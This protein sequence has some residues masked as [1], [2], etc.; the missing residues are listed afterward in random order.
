MA[1]SLTALVGFVTAALIA[2]LL[3]PALSAFLE[4]RGL[5]ADNYRRKAIP[6]CLGLGLL[7][8]ALPGYIGVA[9]VVPDH[10]STAV[11]LACAL[12]LA[13]LAGLL[14]DVAGRGDPKGVRGH[15]AALAAGR[16]TAGTLKAAGLTG[17]G[18]L[19]AA[20]TATGWLQFG[21]TVALVA[22]SANALNSFDLRPGRAGK[23]FLAGAVLL[24][25]S[26]V[27]GAGRSPIFLA[28]LAGGLA[29]YL[30]WDLRGRAMLGD[31]GAN[32]LGAGLGAVAAL[33]LSPAGEAIA[34]LVLLSLHVAT[35][36]A[37]LSA[38]ID[39]NPLLRAL[40]DLGR[41]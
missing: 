27:A 16:C 34:L 40:D 30:P 17:A 5:V 6:T 39:R 25:I 20:A 23:A 13:G 36:R 24:L 12:L 22:L 3:T 9:I 38:V 29:G 11:A 1:I 21:A 2:R 32:L 7:A 15:L 28:P 33:T 10:R 4:E 26:S 31:A 41:R 14:D 19:T 37:S 8:A 18:L 35:E